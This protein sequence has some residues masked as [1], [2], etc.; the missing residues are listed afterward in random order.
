MK[1]SQIL[2]PTT[3]EIPKDAVLTSHI[4]LLRA[5]FIQHVSSGIY[6]LLPLG[7]IVQDRIA[8]VIKQELDKA[9]CNEVQLGFVTPASLW[10]KSGRLNKYGKELLRFK[11][12]KDNEFVLGP[13]HEEMVVELVKQ[14]VNSYKQLPINLYQINTKFRDEI[15]PRFGLMRGREFLMKD[16]YS[17]HATYEDMLSEFEKMEKTYS[18]IFTRLGLDFR[19]VAADSGAIGGSGSKEFM[20]L[21]QSGEDTVVTCTKC[22]YAA[23]VEAAVAKPTPSP[24]T[25]IVAKFAKFHTPGQ[26]TIE[27]VANFFKADPYYVVKTVVKKAIFDEC[28]ELVAFVLRGNDSLQEVKAIN[29]VGANDLVDPTQQDLDDAKIEAGFVGPIDLGIKTVVD[30]SLESEELVIVGANERDYHFVGAVF[31]QFRCDELKDI[32]QVQEGDCCTQCSGKLEYKKGIE[33]GHIFQLEDRYSKPLEATFLDQN[34]KSQNFVMGTYGIGVSRLVAAIIEQNHDEK[35]CKWTK[36]TAPFTVAVIVANAKDEQQLTIGTQIY[37]TLQENGIDTILD[38]RK[39]RF[40]AKMKDFEL[41]GFNYAVIVGKNATSG[42]VEVVNR[43]NLDKIEVCVDE[44]LS[45]V[46]V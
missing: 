21:A 41:I 25:P 11:D 42:T 22:D 14:S 16:G 15:R 18:K 2:I 1:F 36:E 46:G 32:K 19:V 4:L 27:E 23:N 39:D 26:K 13:T 29:A 35:G 33:V 12:R 31:E 45:H 10:Q 44:V 8:K 20:V 7:K 37:D 28:E 3:K 43:T 40:G 17:F 5:G 9:G 34:G 6:N 30:S 24:N 38:D